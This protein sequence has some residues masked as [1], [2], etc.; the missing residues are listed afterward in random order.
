MP[1]AEW[2]EDPALAQRVANLEAQCAQLQAAIE[3]ADARTA[4][5]KA[6]A[7]RAPKSA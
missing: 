7:R 6:A 2:R 3:T 1:N 4:A 5:A